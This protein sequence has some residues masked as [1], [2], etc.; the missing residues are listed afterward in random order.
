MSDFC[1]KWE[2]LRDRVDDAALE[3][4]GLDAETAEVVRWLR[5]LAD[6]TMSLPPSKTD[7]AAGG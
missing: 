2:S 7:G 6:K 5:R 3:S 1:V 4:A